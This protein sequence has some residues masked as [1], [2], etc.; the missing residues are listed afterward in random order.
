MIG[1]QHRKY[2]LRITL[3]HL[4]N[5]LCDHTIKAT[6]MSN[7]KA[8]CHIVILLLGIPKVDP[9]RSHYITLNT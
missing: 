7:K 5:R 4:G 6:V 8:S 1:N 3:F 9:Y 2:N